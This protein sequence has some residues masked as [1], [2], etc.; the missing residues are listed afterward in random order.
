MEKQY[1]ISEVAD[2]TGYT[3][4]TIYQ[5]RKLGQIEGFK[6]GNEWRFTSDQIK[7]FIELKKK[8]AR[9]E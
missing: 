7:A 1:T 9:G 8:Q 2:I 5:Y 3:P 6:M 4:K